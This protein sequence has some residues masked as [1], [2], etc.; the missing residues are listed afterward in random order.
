MIYSIISCWLD[1]FIINSETGGRTGNPKE[2]GNQIRQT[3]HQTTKQAH[4]VLC[5][6][7]TGSAAYLVIPWPWLLLGLGESTY[8][9]LWLLH[10]LIAS[11]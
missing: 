9:Y 3:L 2:K 8:L 6:W 5:A 7:A 4:A 10:L 11:K 1:S